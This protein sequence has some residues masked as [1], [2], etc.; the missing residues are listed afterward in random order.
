MLEKVHFVALDE[1]LLAQKWQFAVLTN[2]GDFEQQMKVALK[3]HGSKGTF[4][5]GDFWRKIGNFQFADFTCPA[6]RGPLRARARNA[7]F[8]KNKVE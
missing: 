3:G 8:L 6:Q 1:L 7:L 2:S 5:K 4:S